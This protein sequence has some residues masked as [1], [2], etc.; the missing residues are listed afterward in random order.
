VT[1]DGAAL[2]RAAAAAVARSA[3]VWGSDDNVTAAVML[4]DWTAHESL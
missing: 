3:L 4:F 2:A 1:D